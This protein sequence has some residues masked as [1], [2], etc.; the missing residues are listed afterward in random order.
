MSRRIAL[1]GFVLI[2]LAVFAERKKEPSETELA[3]I[4][5][6]GRMME[7]YDVAAWHATDAVR[8]LVADKDMPRG[9]YVA[10][11]SDRG[12]A[13]V[14]G[15]LNENHDKYLIFY[16]AVQGATPVDFDVRKYDPPREDSDFYLHSATALR[17]ALTDFEREQRPYN[18]YVLLQD[19][20][21]MYVYILPASTKTGVYPLGG[22]IR[23]LIS[24]DGNNIIE[25]HPMHKSILEFDTSAQAGKI[26]M[27][28]H[29]HVLTDRPEDSDVFYVLSR[30]PP[31]P[32]VVV[33][34]EHEMYLVLA[35]GTIERRKR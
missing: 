7:E 30:K 31:M 14:F 11:K 16:E 34:G 12:W 24:S 17:S 21:Q 20:G 13:V 27:G 29:A 26:V 9:N 3:S 33:T 6:R 15:Q 2:N 10:R 19:T 32:E 25:K 35:D 23:Y 4:T 28:V 22:D 5:A 1:L 18:T 8:A